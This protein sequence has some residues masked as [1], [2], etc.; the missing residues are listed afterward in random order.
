M[1]RLKNIDTTKIQM[2]FLHLDII[3]L[4]PSTPFAAFVCN[5]LD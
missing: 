5:N 1:P 3:L 2:Y 4:L